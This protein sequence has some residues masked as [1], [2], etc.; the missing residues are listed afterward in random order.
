MA[1]ARPR[2]LDEIKRAVAAR[3]KTIESWGL[4]LDEL[5]TLIAENPHVYSPVSG[6]HAEY[7]CRQLH[8]ERDEISDVIKPSGYDRKEKGDFVFTYRD[9]L[10][11]LEVKSLD[12]PSVLQRAGDDSWQGT[13]QCNASD[14]R[15]VA[16]PNGHRVSTN[17]IV[18]GGWDVIAVN[19][20]DFGRKWRFAFARQADLPRASEHYNKEDRKYL[21]A[22]V[23]TIA[24]PLPK[25]FTFDFTS[26]LDAI[27]ALR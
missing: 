24:L 11:R 26:V 9:E 20:Y 2:S 4:S 17:C 14:A 15:E 13:F 10:I 27:V 23:M 19:L 16:L 25:P 6:F 22:S 5:I 8:L 3:R 12:G 21:L 7:K 1:R 18:A